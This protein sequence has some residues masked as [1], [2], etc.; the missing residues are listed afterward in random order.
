MDFLLSEE[1]K[2]LQDMAYKFGQAEIAPVAHE[3]DVQEKYT[4]EVRKKAAEA[5][6]VGAWI[7]EEYNGAGVGF[8]GHSIVT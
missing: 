6:L 2:M 4:P 3:A 8:L 7:P 5:G 1:L